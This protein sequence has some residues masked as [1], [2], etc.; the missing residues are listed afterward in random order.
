MPI[1]IPSGRTLPLQSKAGGGFRSLGVSSDPVGLVFSENFNDLADWDTSANGGAKEAYRWA[2]GV[3]PVGWDA[4]Y[5]AHDVYVPNGN[6]QIASADA[7]DA[8]GGSGKGLKC[9]RINNTNPNFIGQW[10]SDGQLGRLLSD[11]LNDIYV[12]FKLRFQLGW[13]YEDG[14]RAISKMFRIFA[15]PGEI[16]SWFEAFGGGNQGPLFIW[17][18]ENNQYGIRNSVS[19]RGGPYG[20]N[21]SAGRYADPFMEGL[22]RG[23]D[24][25]GT[26]SMNWTSD[27]QGTLDGGGTPAIPDK[28]NGGVLPASGSVS[29]PQVFGPAGTW[30]KMAFRLKMNSAPNIPD[31]LYQ[32]FIDDQLIVDAKNVRWVG[33]TASPMVKWNAISFGGNDLWEGGIYTNADER[34]EWYMFDEIKVFSGLPEGLL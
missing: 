11:G 20:E 15:S 27:L 32:E 17:G 7:A 22:G 18:I 6:I 26:A 4:S 25:A 29:H 9:F 10:K 28:L 13:T 30:T 34:R 33:P 2:G 19:F 12:E 8:F 5:N 3:L 21:Y 16:N 31:G 24:L 23:I 1:S 14:V